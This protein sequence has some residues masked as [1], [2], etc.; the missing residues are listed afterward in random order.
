MSVRLRLTKL[1]SNKD[2]QTLLSC[3][4]VLLRDVFVAPKWRELAHLNQCAPS[5]WYNLLLLYVTLWEPRIPV[6]KELVVSLSFCLN[7][8]FARSLLSFQCQTSFCSRHN[9]DQEFL[10]CRSCGAGLLLLLVSAWIPSS[11]FW[12]LFGWIFSSA[13]LRSFTPL[14]GCSILEVDSL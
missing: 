13:S 8:L 3:L 9:V 14:A 5:V 1:L 6:T 7:A 10:F 2:R 12:V 11:M 4:W